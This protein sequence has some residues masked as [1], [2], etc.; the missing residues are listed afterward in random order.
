MADKNEVLYKIG[1]LTERLNDVGQDINFCMKG[2]KN[3]EIILPQKAQ[4]EDLEYIRDLLD[5]M[6]KRTEVQQVRK[7]LFGSLQQFTEDN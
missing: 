4:N 1:T 6:P 3:I 5:E 7:D 2:V